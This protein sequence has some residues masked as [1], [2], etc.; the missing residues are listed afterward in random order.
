MTEPEGGGSKVLR[1]FLIAVLIVAV[2]IAVALFYRQIFDGLEATFGYI[3]DRFPNETGQQV[4]V[5]V[6]LVVAGLLGILFSHFGHFTAYGV[7]IGLG[8]LLW[9]LFWMGF[10]AVGLE[11]SWAE[12]AGLGSLTTPNVILW[13]AVAVGV[14]T[15]LFIPLELREKYLKRKRSLTTD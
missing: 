8:S 14:I 12:S 7:A 13:A 9:I 6:Y 15:L 2:I 1:G 5:I 11:P 3:S 4:A 10:P